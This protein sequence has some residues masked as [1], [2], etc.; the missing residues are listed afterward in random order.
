MSENFTQA[1]SYF[2]QQN[3]TNLNYKIVTMF[4]GL[5]LPVCTI[6]KTFQIHVPH[7]IYVSVPNPDGNLD[8]SSY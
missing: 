5:V 2:I 6:L 7:G 3:L 4:I 8:K 1:M